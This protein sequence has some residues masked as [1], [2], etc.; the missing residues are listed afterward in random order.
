MSND[1]ST[2]LGRALALVNRAVQEDQDRNFIDAC[3]MYWRALVLLKEAHDV[4]ADPGKQAG[5]RG[6]SDGYE[7]R[8]KELWDSM[9]PAQQEAVVRR[10]EVE[11]DIALVKDLRGSLGPQLVPPSVEEMTALH[12]LQMKLTYALL[13]LKMAQQQQQ[14]GGTGG[15]GVFMGGF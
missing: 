12:D 9:Q 14:P 6:A 5:I 4:E 3:S 13:Q 2:A 7:K 15:G 11:Q 10:Y 8:R 1:E